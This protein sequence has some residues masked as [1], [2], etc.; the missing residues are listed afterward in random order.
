MKHQTLFKRLFFFPI[1]G[2]N[3][4][5]LYADLHRMRRY[6]VRV[7]ELMGVNNLISNPD[8][9]HHSIFKALI[10]G[11]CRLIP[12]DQ[13]YS[14]T[15]FISLSTYLNRK[16]QTFSPVTRKRT[17]HS[18]TNCSYRVTDIMLDQNIYTHTGIQENI[19]HKTSSFLKL[20]Q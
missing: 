3:S 5:L 19:I 2:T 10:S 14:V 4:Y 18:H 16:I 17:L 7:L 13:T 11:F 1:Y 6:S 9:S 15:I 20:D 12:T 8:A